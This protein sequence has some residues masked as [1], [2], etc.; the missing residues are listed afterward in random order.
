MAALRSGDAATARGRFEAAIA[1]GWPGAA[2]RVVLSEACR[3]LGDTAARRAALEE[4]TRLDPGDLRARLFLGECLHAAGATASALPHFAAALKLA[5]SRNDL[6]G[7][8][9]ARLD[10]AA[11]A[12]LEARDALE[13]RLRDALDGLG[14]CPD[15][16]DCEIAE[17]IDIVFARSAPALSQPT[18]FFYPGLPHRGFYP[19]EAFD[20]VPALEAH[21]AAIRQELEG[22]LAAGA[23][24]NPYLETGG[25]EGPSGAHPLADNPDWSAFYLVRQGT[26]EAAG[27]ALCP[28]T[29]ATVEAV[30]GAL[31][32]PAPSVLFSRLM[33]GT[34]IPP[35]HG[36]LNSRLICHL[37]LV[38][39]D[40]CS[41]RVGNDTRT[42]QEG[43]MFLFDDSVEHE[44]WNRATAP[45]T[46][47]I[48]EI[49]HPAIPER[50]RTLLTRL[51]E[52]MGGM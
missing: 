33:P 32:A 43:R 17:A 22:V 50:H 16:A 39:P 25:R 2:V 51:F 41:F 49:W 44:A 28:H 21:T 38:V 42:W 9:T 47:L 24:F 26:R 48:F 3:L 11:A 34:H 12:S 35:H 7:D 1:A 52:V 15:G 19:R 18:R 23:A 13:G 27:I 29:L 37:P 20:W 6:P 40:G 10:A 45:R 14:Y 8:L 5:G 4:A 31:P 46:V 30:P 36:M